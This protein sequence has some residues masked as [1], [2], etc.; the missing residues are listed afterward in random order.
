MLYF[1]I[2]LDKLKV[3]LF[4]LLNI[5]C[6]K[7]FLRIKVGVSVLWR[8]GV[9]LPIS[10]MVCFTWIMLWISQRY[11]YLQV[12]MNSMSTTMNISTLYTSLFLLK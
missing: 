11:Q 9:P 2:P 3:I 7:K 8:L 4:F 6:M 5:R 10:T 1:R 12:N